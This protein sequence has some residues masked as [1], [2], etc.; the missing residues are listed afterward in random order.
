MIKTPINH[1]YDGKHPWLGFINYS[2]Y[3]VFWRI[4]GRQLKHYHLHFVY[5]FAT[6]NS[7][8]RETI[9]RKPTKAFGK[10]SRYP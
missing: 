4:H 2:V 6:K 7:H 3:F 1:E 10:L 9:Q 5:E 8:C